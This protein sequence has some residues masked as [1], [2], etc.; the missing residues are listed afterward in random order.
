MVPCICGKD[1]TVEKQ[2]KSLC[3]KC[4]TYYQGREY[5]VRHGKDMTE[6]ERERAKRLAWRTTGNK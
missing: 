1:A 2:G 6:N 5:P 4:S 3:S